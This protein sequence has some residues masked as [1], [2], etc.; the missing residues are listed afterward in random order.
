MKKWVLLSIFF[1]C[2]IDDFSKYL[3]LIPV[4][5]QVEKPY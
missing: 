1:Q 5:I 2:P 3:Y 4:Q